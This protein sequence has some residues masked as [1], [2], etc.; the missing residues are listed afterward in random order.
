MRNLLQHHKPVF[1]PNEITLLAD[2]FDEAWKAYGLGYDTD[3]PHR[4]ARRSTLAARILELGRYGDYDYHSLSDAALASLG[5]LR[6]APETMPAQA[7]IADRK[8]EPNL[9]T[10]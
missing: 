5:V 9:R 6:T 2:A 3:G 8:A 4:D 10:P 7:P 1:S